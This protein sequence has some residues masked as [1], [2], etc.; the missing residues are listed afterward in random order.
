MN[1]V[2]ACRSAWAG[3]GW[4]CWELASPLTVAPAV[5]PGA[6][7]FH[8]TTAGSPPASTI[9][10]STPLITWLDSLEAS[11]RPNRCG[12]CRASSPWS[13]RVAI[14]GL[15]T[16]SFPTSRSKSP[17]GKCWRWWLAATSWRLTLYWRQRIWAL[18]AMTNY[19]ITGLLMP[20]FNTAFLMAEP[21]CPVQGNVWAQRDSLEF[22]LVCEGSGVIATRY[23]RPHPPL[24]GNN[25]DNQAC[26]C[27]LTM[28]ALCHTIYGC[29]G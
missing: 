17:S 8:S 23:N 13:V 6:A 2:A 15:L 5:D 14:L 22:A 1:S 27:F 10:R 25:S 24:A 9:A 28:P 21:L 16:L 7:S 20:I 11:G 18:N 29:F 4:P 19:V 12:F 26:H 3:G